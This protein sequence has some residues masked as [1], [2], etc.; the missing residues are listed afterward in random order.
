MDPDWGYQLEKTE[1][2]DDVSW[3]HFSPSPRDQSN[4]WSLSA[5][6]DI[7]KK[8]V[9]TRTSQKSEK[10]SVAHCYFF[11]ELAPVQIHHAYTLAGICFEKT[12]YKWHKLYFT[13]QQR[14][15]NNGLVFKCRILHRIVG[16]FKKMQIVEFLDFSPCGMSI[17]FIPYRNDKIWK[18]LK[19]SGLLLTLVQMQTLINIAMY[20]RVLQKTGILMTSLATASLSRRPLLNGVCYFTWSLSN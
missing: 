18:V 3:I 5:Q 20:L 15:D 11:S 12:G 2:P 8:H 14:T 1:I 6:W 17:H 9:S 7:L 19:K 13:L 10:I 16:R 4:I